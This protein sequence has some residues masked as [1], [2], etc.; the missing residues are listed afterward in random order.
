MLIENASS[1]LRT[2]AW[3]YV[4]L[5]EVY[6]SGRLTLRPAGVRPRKDSS[7]QTLHPSGVPG[8][9]ATDSSERSAREKLT[10][11]HNDDDGEGEITVYIGLGSNLGNR[12]ANL[13]EAIARMEELGIKVACRSSIYETEPVGFKDQPW[14]LNQVIAFRVDQDVTLG[15]AATAYLIKS[16]CDQQ[17]FDYAS[18]LWVHELHRA[19]QRIERDMG[20][21][22]TVPDGPRVIDIDLL[23]CG[24]MACGWAETHGFPTARARPGY[25]TI[26][27][28]RMHL[29]RFVL[30]PLC[31][32]APEAIHPVLKKT[33]GEILASLDDPSIVRRYDPTPT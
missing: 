11:A 20:R 3:C 4:L 13:R 1:V 15:D 22:R 16:A 26:P 29:R 33:C 19:L 17:N 28:P 7:L 9:C 8:P 14:F 31:E 32:I 30:E 24:D 21:E 10:H 5:R 6:D 18:L 12:E 2:P 27:H 23:L 25:L